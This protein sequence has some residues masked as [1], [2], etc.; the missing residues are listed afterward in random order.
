M[1]G[2][3]IDGNTMMKNFMKVLDSENIKYTYDESRRVVR[4]KYT[5]D[6]FKSLTFV[7][8]FDEDGESV[9]I[10]VFSI[11][12]FEP[13]QLSDAYAFCNKMNNSYRWVSCYVD[14]DNELTVSMDAELDPVSG[15]KECRKLLRR[16]VNITDDI[17][18]ELYS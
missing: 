16:V 9:A 15:G 17:C 4:C 8:I 14:K 6:H 18:G 12:K 1:F 2:K 11:E 7:F 5:G 10:R 13:H 3:K